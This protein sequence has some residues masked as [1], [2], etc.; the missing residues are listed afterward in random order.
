MTDT[1][2]HS[3]PLEG[4]GEVSMTFWDHL[5]ELRGVIIKSLVVMAVAAAVAVFIWIRNARSAGHCTH[6]AA[7][8]RRQEDS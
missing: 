8:V 2:R 6:C 7:A 3:P 4:Q 5:D 1:G